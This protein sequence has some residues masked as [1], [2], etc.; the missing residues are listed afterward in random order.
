MN[1]IFLTTGK[2]L[3]AGLMGAAIVTMIV[4]GVGLTAISGQRPIGN[5]EAW[6]GPPGADLIELPGQSCGPE[7]KIEHQLTGAPLYDLLMK[8]R[9]GVPPRY[10]RGGRIMAEPRPAA[11]PVPEI[12]A[13]IVTKMM[14]CR[15]Q[16]GNYEKCLKS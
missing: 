14:I 2:Q 12:E 16:G 8:C 15:R 6:G 1:I 11:R 10:V 13:P 4:G 3:L 7:M 9:G 5:A